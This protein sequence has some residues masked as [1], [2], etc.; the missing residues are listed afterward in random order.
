MPIALPNDLKPF[1]GGDPINPLPIAP[2]PGIEKYLLAG[3]TAGDLPGIILFFSNLLKV[4]VYAAGI[5]GLINLL[6]SGIQY[7]GSAGNPELLKQASSRIWLSFLGLVIIAGSL[8]IAAILG[9]VFFGNP[10]FFLTPNIP[11]V[12]N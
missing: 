8:V 10:A 4:I 1:F 3:G 2:P 9:L 6:I 11:N 12:L 7:I 5:F